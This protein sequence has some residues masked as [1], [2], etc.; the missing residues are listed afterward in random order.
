[1]GRYRSLDHWRGFSA[2]AVLLFHVFTS[3]HAKLGTPML[4]SPLGYGWLGV[5]L[6][7]VISGY[8]VTERLA[9]EHKEGGSAGRFLLDRGWRLLPPY[10]ATLGLLLVLRAAA[11]PFNGG[12]GMPSWGDWGTAVVLLDKLRSGE[13]V[14]LVAWS[15]AYEFVFYFVAAG[16]FLLVHVSRRVWV[17]FACAGLLAILAWQP[18]WP[19]FHKVAAGWVQ[20]L[21]G[22]VVWLMLHPVRARW[23]QAL[24]V[25]GFVTVALLNL[26]APGADQPALPVAAVFAALLLLAAPWD[27]K[28]AELPL[29]RPMSWLGGIS[30]SLYLTHVPI[31]S[32]LR[33]LLERVTPPTPLALGALGLFCTAVAIAGAGWFNQLIERRVET[34]RR[35]HF[36]PADSSA[37]QP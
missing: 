37:S 35:R 4:T 15:L 8:C 7:F 28:I 32:P 22:S 2:L 23:L 16:C 9:R 25:T 1:V 18:C 33:N 34:V 6:F 20:F 31:V 29:L 36:R 26:G 11:M 24:A 19:V 17:G 5:S 12:Q 21:F 13:H 30:Y 3:M 27:Q 10:W 14:L